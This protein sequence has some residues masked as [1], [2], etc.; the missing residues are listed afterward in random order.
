[1]SLDKITRNFES[2]Y[3]LHLRDSFFV[4]HRITRCT[5]VCVVQESVVKL[6]PKLKLSCLQ[7]CQL[8]LCESD[9]FY[10]GRSLYQE[11]RLCERDSLYK[12]QI[13]YEEASLCERDSLYKS[14]SL[15]Q[16]E[17]LRGIYET[18]FSN[19]G[20]CFAKPDMNKTSQFLQTIYK[21]LRLNLY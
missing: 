11:A 18:L 14:R 16:G 12:G 2:Y 3:A 10:T 20:H 17:D 8:S 4:L 21:I 6:T 7:C 5:S 13:L 15:Y 9:S 19:F 1:M